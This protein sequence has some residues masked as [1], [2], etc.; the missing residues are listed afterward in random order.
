MAPRSHCPSGILQHPTVLR[1]WPRVTTRRRVHRHVNPA[2]GSVTC[3]MQLATLAD[4]ENAVKAARAALPA[5]RALAG[6]KRRDLMLRMATLIERHAQDLVELST[7]ENGCPSV[8]AAYIAA[9]AA[10]RFRHFAAL[11]DPTFDPDGVLGAIIPWNGPLLAATEV[12]PP[13]LAAGNCMVM[14]MSKLA[15][16]SVMRL[17]RM[18]MEAGF[19][20][21]VVNIL[22]GESDIDQALIRHVGIDRVQFCIAQAAY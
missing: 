12:M 14:S 6:D 15:P 20:P 4:L 22:V 5:W 13:T 16:F 19:P 21:G 3:E 8:A 7:L 11:V 9:D 17:G 10:R 1:D 18:F 2:N